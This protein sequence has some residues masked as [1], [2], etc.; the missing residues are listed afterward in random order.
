MEP[1]RETEVG[2]LNVSA[3]VE[4]N[5]VGFNI[6]ESGK[7]AT[8]SRTRRQEN[9]LNVPMYESKLVHGLDGQSKLSHVETSDIL[10]E[11]FVL[12]KHG[13]QVTTGQEFH[14]H[15]QESVVLESSVQLDDPRA[16]RLGENVT[17]R[18]DVGKLVLLELRQGSKYRLSTS[19]SLLL[20]ISALIRDFKA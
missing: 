15:V 16:V 6:T 9:R 5:V 14:Q 17:L 20:T 7:Y 10:G 11:D 13:H 18:A 12:D 19:F 4:K 8:T 3:A 2:E 1:G